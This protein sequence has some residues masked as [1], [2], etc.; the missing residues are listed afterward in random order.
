MPLRGRSKGQGCKDHQLLPWVGTIYC[1][2]I[3]N[4]ILHQ[5]ALQWSIIMHYILQYCKVG[6]YLLEYMNFTFC[7]IFTE[8]NPAKM[9]SLRK[10]LSIPASLINSS[11]NRN[12]NCNINCNTETSSNMYY[13]IPIILY[14]CLLHTLPSCIATW[15]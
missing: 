2:Y 3:W 8:K 15:C 14:G 13:N 6:Q 10:Y 11:S 12:T 7:T 1:I 4:S 5:Y 9:Y